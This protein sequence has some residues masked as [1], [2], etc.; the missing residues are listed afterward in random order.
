[1]KDASPLDGTIT[2]QYIPGVDSPDDPWVQP[3]QKVWKENGSGGELTTYQIS[4]MKVVL[5]KG[6]QVED[7]TPV[8]VTDVG[9]TPINPITEDDSVSKEAPAGD[10]LPAQ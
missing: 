5:I 7:L 2:T 4:G 6:A 3:W 1:M 10:G 8:Q 9:D